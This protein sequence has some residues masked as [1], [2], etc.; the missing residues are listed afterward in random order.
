MALRFAKVSEEE[1]KTE[2]SPDKEGQQ[3]TLGEEEGKP[4]ACAV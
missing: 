2:G 1:I 4:S 3:V